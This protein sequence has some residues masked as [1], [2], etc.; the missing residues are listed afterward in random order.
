VEP[1]PKASADWLQSNA[2]YLAGQSWVDEMDV[3]SRDM[4][5]YWGVGRLRTLV[6]PELREKFDRQRF[7]VNNAIWCGDLEEVKTETKRMVAAWRALDR[8]AKEAGHRR[9]S[10]ETW[11]IGLKDGSVLVLCRSDDDARA[12]RPDGRQTVVWT[13]DEVRNMIDSEAWLNAAKR[14]FPGAVVQAS[15]TQIADPLACLITGS[16]LDDP[17]PF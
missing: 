12:V 14:E 9:L 13:L 7:K 4:E 17:I 1:R 11:E 3:V 10:P 2:T 16:A 15:K 8:A 5:R 6:T